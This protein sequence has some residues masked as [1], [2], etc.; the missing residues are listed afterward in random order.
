MN[1]F[2][3]KYGAHIIVEK[4][5][6]EMKNLI[7]FLNSNFFIIIGSKINVISLVATE[8]DNKIDDLK[9]LS[10]NVRSILI[11]EMP[12]VIVNAAA[13]TN[14]E[15]AEVEQDLAFTVNGHALINIHEELSIMVP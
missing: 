4:I 9:N 11:R 6:N 10:N 12:D 1:N 8:I 2:K 15:K 3:F 7:F 13:Y 5:K 14:V